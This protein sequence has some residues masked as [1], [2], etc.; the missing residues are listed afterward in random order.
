MEH[1][2]HSWVARPSWRLRPSFGKFITLLRDASVAAE[3]GATRTSD[4]LMLAQL[5]PAIICGVAAGAVAMALPPAVEMA[6]KRTGGQ[7]SFR[8]VSLIV[9]LC[10]GALLVVGLSSFLW[11]R[12]LL[13]LTARDWPARDVDTAAGYVAGFF[14][15]SWLLAATSLIA[16]FLTTRKVFLAGGLAVALNGLFASVVVLT[17]G[18]RLGGESLVIGSVIDGACGLAIVLVVLAFV[19]RGSEGLRPERIEWKSLR[20]IAM[21]AIVVSVLTHHSA[22]CGAVGRGITCAW[23]RRSLGLGAEDCRLARLRSRSCLCRRRCIRVSL[24]AQS[25]TMTPRT[26]A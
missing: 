24:V 12:P 17:L 16:V 22:A 4:E 5:Y 13:A 23:G 2:R 26:S 10:M 14:L 1:P 18:G 11:A 20:A 8:Q 7:P 9:G 3:F 25:R 21:P 15:F 6:R 19:S